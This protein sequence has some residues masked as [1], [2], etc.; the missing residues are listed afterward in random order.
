MVFV[1]QKQKDLEGTRVDIQKCLKENLKSNRIR[2]WEKKRKKSH[3][4]FQC[5]DYV[6]NPG[7]TFTVFLEN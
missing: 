2:Y 5:G 6:D 4:Q 7:K 3:L 1:K